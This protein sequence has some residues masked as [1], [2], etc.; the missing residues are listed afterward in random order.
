MVL[1]NEVRCVEKDGVIHG[2]GGTA[3]SEPRLLGEIF[4]TTG[5]VIRAFWLGRVGLWLIEQRW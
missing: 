5:A 2:E 1:S 4:V 3:A